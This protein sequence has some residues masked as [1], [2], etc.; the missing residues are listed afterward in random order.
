MSDELIIAGQTIRSRFLIGTGKFASY[1]TMKQSIVASGAHIVTV[2]LRRVEQ[3]S[4]AANIIDF[5]PPGL[6]LMTNTSGARN[7]DEAI[8][9]ARI[10]RAA[11]CGDWI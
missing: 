2:A 3:G 5:I 8:R 11:G 9:I 7:A 6:I 10:A 1:E 4:D